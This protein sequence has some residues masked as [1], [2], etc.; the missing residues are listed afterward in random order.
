MTLQK[1]FVASALLSSLLT[2]GGAVAYGAIPP[3]L[4]GVRIPQTPGLVD[5]ADPIVVDKSAAI[6]LGKA[7]FWDVN[8]GEDGVA[9]ATC[10]F[11]AGADGRFRNQVAPGERHK[12]AQSRRTFSTMP[13]GTGGGPNYRMTTADFPLYRLSDPSDNSSTVLYQTDDI[14]GSA[15]TFRAKLDR[16]AGDGTG[17]CVATPDPVFHLG[18][19]NTR[20]VTDRHTPSVINAAFNFRQFWDGRANNIFNGSSPF[21]V[22]DADAG[23]WVEGLDGLVAK[24]TVRLV[25]S[26]LASQAMSPPLSSVEMGCGQR[27]FPEIARGLLHRHALDKQEVHA[28]DS[29]LA[30]LR[31]KSGIGLKK[32]Y[33]DLIREAFAARFWSNSGPVPGQDGTT[34]SAYTQME[35]NFSF[36]F[37]IALQLYQQTLIS[38]RTPLDSARSDD[39]TGMPQ[40]LNAQQAAGLRVFVAAQCALCHKGPTLSAAAH[41]DLYMDPDSDL[42]TLRL[43]NRKTL[44]G[45]FTGHGVAQGLVD[46]GYFNTSVVPTA[47]DLGVG[48]ADPYGNPLSFTRQ[49]VQSLKKRGALVDPVEVY[50]CELDNPFAM[51]FSAS[52]LVDDVAIKDMCGIRALYAKVPKRSV[53][54]AELREGITSRVIM[55]TDGAFKVPSLRNIE[56]TAPYMHDGSM[57]TLEEVV[58]F[59]LR[60]G[61]ANNPHHFATL[62]FQQHF[63]ATDKANLVE[64]LKALTD[65]RVRWEKAPFDHPQLLVPHG[66]AETPDPAQPTR[67]EDIYIHVPAVGRN[68][69]GAALGPLKPLPD[70]ME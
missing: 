48:G 35:M 34:G 1:T 5:G 15:G 41:P 10:H 49:Y 36:F 52:E 26:S 29:V 17:K 30:E 42:R 40:G 43:V 47:H 57:L 54:V 3:S 64:F 56:L 27:T 20:Q 38:D 4:Q 50:S 66:H 37:G 25:N 9:C 53:L 28:Q 68:G 23:V 32:T 24:Q 16:S 46:E 22:R 21:G 6:Q 2:S 70:M 33:A 67:A 62:V 69:R 12:G 14:I 45:S 59:Y 60:G 39:G 8:V 63:S 65:E 18:A 55:A 58:E 19:L 11:H 31:R 44:N 13:S 51:D 7:L 61:N